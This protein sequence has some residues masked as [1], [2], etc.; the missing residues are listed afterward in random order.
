MQFVW[1]GNNAVISW[2]FTDY[3]DGFSVPDQPFNTSL[4]F[5]L[6]P[7]RCVVYID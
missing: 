6:C 4:L 1:L 7:L 3:W 2:G 5:N